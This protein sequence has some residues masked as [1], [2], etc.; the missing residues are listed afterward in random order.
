MWTI[1]ASDKPQII[2]HHVITPH[3]KMESIKL[4]KDLIQKGYWLPPNCPGICIRCRQECFIIR[5]TD[6]VLGIHSGFQY[7][8]NFI[9]TTEIRLLVKIN[10]APCREDKN[11][12][13]EI[14][15]V[16]GTMVTTHPAILPTP[17]HYRC[18]ERTKTF[19]LFRGFSF[20]SSVPMNEDIQ[21]DL[22]W[23]I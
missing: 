21:L 13:R 15:H 3:F 22:M 19:Y 17:L 16:P 7:N 14:S 1:K 5:A 4:V 6:R 9:T 8:D 2:S 12:L 18:L 10:K 11:N 23:W 20:D